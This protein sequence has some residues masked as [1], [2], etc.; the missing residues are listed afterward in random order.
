MVYFIPSGQYIFGMALRS[1][2]QATRARLLDEAARLVASE[3][4]SALTLERAATAAGISKGAVLY[5][6]KSKD[7]LVEALVRKALDQFD[8][9]TQALSDRDRSAGGLV[10]AY[11][12][13]SFNP[14]TNTP[15]A[16]AG[17]LAAVTTNIDLLK[18][19]RLRH[20]DIQTRLEA[21]GISPALATL[22]RLAS[23]GLYFTRAFGL[24]PLSNVQ[25]ASVQKLLLDLVADA[26]RERR[27]GDD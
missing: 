22:V 7:A 11:A 12:R 8:A 25:A 26:L 9:A 13:V 6:F 20:T 4:P 2:G 27:A 19:A 18:P 21:D 1:D 10:R 5:H 23:D 16:A 14:D 15:E 3:G 24:A 17:L